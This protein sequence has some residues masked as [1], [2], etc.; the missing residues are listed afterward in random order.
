MPIKAILFDFGDT[1]VDETYMGGGLS[2]VSIVKLPCADATLESL[3][4][5]F[6]LGMLTNTR[7][8]RWKDVR[9]LLKKAGWDSYFS[10]VVT[11]VDANSW[12][13]GKHIFLKAMRLLGV[14]PSECV[15]VGNKISTDIVGGNR[16]GAKTVLLRWNDRYPS[17]IKSADEQPSL[18]IDSLEKLPSAIESLDDSDRF[19]SA[20][21]NSLTR[22]E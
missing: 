17:V 13:P 2:D 5:S 16:V 11:S 1:L 7:S 14:G 22:N 8:W 6:K 18:I 9:F 4:R 15:V 19:G 3:A 12:K 20:I 21:G 10:C